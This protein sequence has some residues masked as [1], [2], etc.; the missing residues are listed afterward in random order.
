MAPSYRLVGPLSSPLLIKSPS[1]QSNRDAVE[2]QDPTGSPPWG[3]KFLD[4]GPAGFTPKAF[5]FTASV[6]NISSATPH[7]R[8]RGT[9]ILFSSCQTGRCVGT[10]GCR[11]PP[12]RRLRPHR[13]QQVAL[14][15]DQSQEM[16]LQ[17][18]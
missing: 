17:N 16:N 7:G 1:L 13:P 12:P 11:H 18:T 4:A 10:V 3:W 9:S 14:V 5:V 15:N 6:T 8:P 2:S